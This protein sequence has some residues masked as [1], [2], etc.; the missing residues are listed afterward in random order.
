[1][2]SLYEIE[3]T[4]KRSAKAQGLS[5]GVSEEVGK[6]IRYLEQSN[7]VGLESFKRIIDIGLDN[8]TKLLVIEQKNNQNLCPIHFGLFFLDQSH[9]KN[10]HQKFYFD[11]LREPLIIIPFLSKAAKK[12]LIY[13]QLDSAEIK[14]SITPSDILS[15]SNNVIPHTISKFSISLTVE[16]QTLYSTETWDSLYNLSLDTFVEESE[17]KKLSGAGAGLTDND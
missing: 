3:T 4:V 1:M 15:L 10:L 17:E 14:L 8:L 9:K 6:A 2:Q 5:W 13:F 11:S 7:L 12:N 16:R